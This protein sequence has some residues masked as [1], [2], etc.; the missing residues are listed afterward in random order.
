MAIPSRAK[1][2]A[3][4]LLLAAAAA[5]MFA[6]LPID[7]KAET[8]DQRFTD[9]GNPY[10]AKDEV[11]QLV[12]EGIINGYQDSQFRPGINIVRGQAAN[13][14]TVALDLPRAPY[15]PI[16]KDISPK[17]SHLEGAMA[18]YQAKI[19]S[20][21]PDGNFGTGDVLTREQMAS[22]LVRAFQLEDTGEEVHFTDD[23]KISESHKFGVKVLMQHGITTGKEDGSFDPKAPIN[24]G[25]FVVFLHRAMIQTGL[26]EKKPL[27]QFNEPAV[28]G[29]FE[30]VRHKQEFVEVP[31]TDKGQTFLR[32]NNYIQLASQHVTNYAHA[33]DR[34]FT[35]A[36]S[37]LKGGKVTITKRELPNGDYFIFTEL[38]NPDRLPIRVDLVQ[39]EEGIDSNTI[40]RF[41]KYP[42]RKDIDE[43][44]GFDVATS[45]VGVV[46][47]IAGEKASE[48]M[49]SKTYRSRDLTMSYKNGAISRTRE[50]QEEKETYNNIL[51]GG[52]RISIYEMNSRGYDIVD[53]WLLSSE[54]Q[55]FSTDARLDAWLK[56]S[57][58]NY[59]KRNKWYTAQGPYNK[60]ATTIEP[61]PASGRGYGRNLLLVKEDRAMVLYNETK[62]RYY[63]D[64]LMNA[65]T[66]LNIFRGSKT[67]WDTEVTSTYL[68]H[69]YGITAPFVDTRF[70]EQIALF[71]YNGGEAFNHTD[72]NEGLRNYANLLVQQHRKGNVSK[73]SSTAYYIPD[74]FPEKQ[75]VHTHTSMNHLLGGM[76]ILLLAYKEFKDPVYL[77]N[78]GAIEKAIR[79]EEKKWTRADGDIWYK[80]APDGVFSG[81]DYVHLTLEDLIKSYEMWSSV[82]QGRAKV[83]ERMIRS[84]AGYLNANRKGYTTKIRE[85][86][87]RIKMLDVLPRGPEYTDAL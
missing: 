57:V 36:V 42:F 21:K 67:Y 26:L 25:S 19:F 13:L 81:R 58:E 23:A 20:G 51:M 65:F 44:F 22:V 32:S 78:A 72:Y 62:E 4:A 56:E 79:T 76:N 24:R 16:F 30:P 60:M 27:I 8:I 87:E 50:L 61:M 11:M 7:T 59:K 63:E 31:L 9:I 6:I 1:K 15:A 85:G 71:Q 38:R 10:W 45:P 68:K 48:Q 3:L 69:L 28:T 55:L 39:V 18:T 41:S 73:L 43:T 80:R 47:S 64:L 5:A 66:N 12:E 14:L 17:S 35:Y 74:Y 33:T 70:N 54:E 84:K 37:G 49:V 52:K 2:A 83:F 29:K 75:Q 40:E 86:L 46:K 77:E 82:D 34:V 53:Q